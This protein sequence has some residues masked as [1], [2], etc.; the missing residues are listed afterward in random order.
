MCEY[1]LAVDIVK[2]EMERLDGKIA[3]LQRAGLV[4]SAE[5]KQLLANLAAVGSHILMSLGSALVSAGERL[6][7]E[8]TS[9]RVATI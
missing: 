7:D 9:G 5:E 8:R 2:W 3:R 6:S 1:I 4:R